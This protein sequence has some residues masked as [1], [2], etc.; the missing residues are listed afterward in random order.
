[1]MICVD[2]GMQLQMSQ[3]GMQTMGTNQATWSG[4]TQLGFGSL[5]HLVNS[6]LLSCWRVGPQTLLCS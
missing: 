2:V 3:T 4:E 6:L 5:L 1:M